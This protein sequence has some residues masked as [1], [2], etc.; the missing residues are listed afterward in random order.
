MEKKLSKQDIN[1]FNEILLWLF[2]GSLTTAISSVLLRQ[3]LEYYHN[4]IQISI[5]ICFSGV[6]IFLL[7]KIYV[8]NNKLYKK[9]IIVF[10]CLIKFMCQSL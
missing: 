7:K 3:G 5:L 9:I 4:I 6:L 10:L 8:N 1:A 2:C